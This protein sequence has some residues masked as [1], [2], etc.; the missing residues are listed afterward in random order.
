MIFS[1]KIRFWVRFLTTLIG[2]KQK[3]VFFGLILGVFFY[4]FIPN[5]IKYLPKPG[6]TLKIGILGQYQVN[7]I[8]TEILKDI[9][10]GLTALSEKGEPEPSLAES[11]TIHDDGNTYIFKISEKN[12]FW[13]DGKEFQ[14]Q[15]INYN[16]KDIEFSF[17]DGSLTFR[18]KEP[19]S[20][21]L[22]ILSKPLFR[23]GLIGLGSYKVKKITKS[24]KFVSSIYLTPVNNRSLPNKLYRFY[25][26]EG[27][28][29]TGFN[30]GEIN[31]IN[32]IFNLDNL[33]LGRNAK[34]EKHIMSNA[35]V[36]VFLNTGSPPFSNKSSR[37]ALA[38]AI[39]KESLPLRALGP[40]DPDSWAYNPDIK[41][42]KED[43]EHSR[44]LLKNEETNFKDL[45]IIISTMLQFEKMAEIVKKNW[46]KLGIKAEIQ[47][48]SAVPENFDV[49]IIAREIPSDPDQ[50]Y[51]WHSIQPG[52]L[53][54]FK[55]P[56]IDKL[57]EDGRKIPDKEER[58]SVYFDF[59][60]YLIEESPVIFL[61]HPVVFE[62]TRN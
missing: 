59:Q 41:P 42:Y 23:K 4:F 53:S 30:L 58:K 13:H 54:N 12:L 29:K 16:F 18:L 35:Y 2:K 49:L 51:F 39:Q 34:F 37:Q 5:V 14:I 26:N 52:N 50:Y 48:V 60:R 10:F 11:W 46:E 45:K 15:D 25:N 44:E 6:R 8:P 27:D 9:S 21:F 28:L 17:S 62:V 1:K 36:G 32:N 19:F 38:Y 20:P 22:N 33:Y 24:G 3:I 57:L 56:R 40:I 55:N 7:E 31:I 43:L 61:T 47:I